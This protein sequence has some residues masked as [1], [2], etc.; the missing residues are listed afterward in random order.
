MIFCVS[1][2]IFSL[3]LTVR[4][5]LNEN[6]FRHWYGTFFGSAILYYLIKPCSK[7]FYNNWKTLWQ[8]H[9]KRYITAED[10]TDMDHHINSIFLSKFLLTKISAGTGIIIICTIR[11][12]SSKNIAPIHFTYYCMLH[13]L[14]NKPSL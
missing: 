5:R 10:F 11:T 9:L 4:E 7:F 14:S 13:F 2:F 12:C 8:R 6:D 1:I 3:E